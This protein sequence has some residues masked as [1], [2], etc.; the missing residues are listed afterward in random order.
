[1]DLRAQGTQLQSLLDLRSPPVALAFRSAPPPDVQRI[2]EPGPAGCS[3]WKLAADGQIFF[4]EASDHY[5]CPI[6]AHTHGVELPGEV[7]RELQG[8]VETMVGLEYV[9]MEEVPRIPRRRTAFD[10]AIY[11]PLTATP[12]DPDVVLVRGNPKQMMLIAE[13]VRA[14]RISDDMAAKLRPTCAIVPE[15]VEAGHANLSLG[16]IGNRVYT[17]LGDDEVYC[18]L[19][20]S[21]VA[22]V[23][24]KLET[25]IAANRELEMF[26]YQRK[27]AP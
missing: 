10:V 14:A 15:A 19:P 26:H 21:K 17:G 6:G 2:S 20:A 8:L 27:S 3:Y 7:A 11:A 18:A 1:M 5:T 25:I 16:C 13:A 12:V 24:Q 9:Q 4:T 23:V 22:A